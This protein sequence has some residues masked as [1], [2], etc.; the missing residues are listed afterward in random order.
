MRLIDDLLDVSRII[1]RQ[2]RAAP[3]A[4]RP[5]R[6]RASGGRE[7]A[8]RLLEQRRPRAGRA[9]GRQPICRRPTATRLAQ[10]F[11]NL[12][13]NAAQVHRS[14][15]A[16]RDRASRSRAERRGPECSD[17]GIGI[18]PSMQRRGLRDV[19]RRSTSSLERGRA[20]LGVGLALARAARR[21]ARR[22]DRASR[23]RASARARPS[24]SACR[25]CRRRRRAATGAAPLAAA[26]AARLRILI[27]DDNDDY[28]D[29]VAVMLAGCRPSRSQVVY[30]GNA[31]LRAAT[32]RRPDVGLL[33][34]GMPG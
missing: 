28:A 29:S 13:N 34:I 8:R 20:G 26:G 25:G 9:I 14:G 17:N 16:D 23:A 5:G 7:R 22:H 33:D 21:D 12:L 19:R 27:A 24:P 15:R 32:A 10:V 2:A 31:A 11:V 1:H 6:G 18:D 4:G 3:R 30:D